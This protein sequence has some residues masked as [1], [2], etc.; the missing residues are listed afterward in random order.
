MACCGCDEIPVRTQH[1][2]GLGILHCYTVSDCRI[3]LLYVLCLRRTRH[4]DGHI[5]KKVTNNF[6]TLFDKFIKHLNSLLITDGR[7]T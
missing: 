6:R 1:H 7:A 3:P 5:Q 2:A 4:N